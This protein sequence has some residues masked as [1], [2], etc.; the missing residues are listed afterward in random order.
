MK[1]Y[2]MLFA[3]SILLPCTLPLVVRAQTQAAPVPAAAQQRLRSRIFVYDLRDGS[4]KLVY[5]AD[6]VWEAPSWSPDGKY[7]ISNSGG[8]IYKL[9]FRSDGTATPERL[10]IPAEYRCNND[11]AISPD[12]K[13]LAF[14]ATLPPAKNS[15][16][17]VAN[18]DGTGIHAMTT[19]VP[20][21]FHGWSP[22]GKTLAFVA[23]RSGSKDYNILRMPATGGAEVAMTK[24]PE[25]N[26]GPDYTPDGKWLYINS[27]RTGHQSIY[28][29]RPM[30]TSTDDSKAELLLADGD[31]DWFPHPSLDGKKLVYIAYP[32]GTATHNPRDVQVKLMLAGV[33]GD[34]VDETAKVLTTFSGGQGT[35][36]VNSWA[37]DSQRFAYVSYEVLK[38]Q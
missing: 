17:Y 1:I 5:T 32:A 18:A 31:E 6:T 25:H 27:D 14:S 2:A 36:N 20:S 9:A 11:K 33:N 13:L 26:D 21:Y 19:E 28:R 7:L 23:Q 37:P 12:G 34:Q 30:A 29:I 3:G 4:S 22:D 8:G 16:V 38:D 35:L 24:A 10:P 15:N